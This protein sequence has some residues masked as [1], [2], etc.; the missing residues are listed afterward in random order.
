M[1]NLENINR[2]KEIFDTSELMQ[3]YLEELPYGYILLI[4]QPL[5]FYKNMIY[6]NE[7]HPSFNKE[8]IPVLLVDNDEDMICL[9]DNKYYLFHTYHEYHFPY[10]VYSSAQEVWDKVIKRELESF[11]NL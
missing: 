9:H 5:L 4:N 6:I 8:I 10:E 2:L 7:L 3:K 1:T 11:F